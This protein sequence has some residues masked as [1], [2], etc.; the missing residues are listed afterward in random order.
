[1]DD[2]HLHFEAYAARDVVDVRVATNQC[3]SR[4]LGQ[5]VDYGIIVEDDEVAANIL[6][7]IG[8]VELHA[9]VSPVRV[10]SVV[11]S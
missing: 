1:M 5:I 11:V 4:L 2:A 6:E 10:Q 3:Q 9:D 8:N 7:V